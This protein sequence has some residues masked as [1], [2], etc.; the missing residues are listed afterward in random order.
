MMLGL[1]ARTFLR[2][3]V[4][5]VFAAAAQC[6]VSCLQFNF[7]CAGLP[8]LP[9]RLDASV[10]ERIRRS[11]REHRLSLAAVSGT[12]NMI[13]PD[14]GEREA[15]LRR[16]EVVSAACSALGTKLVTLCTGTRDPHDM[17]R[18]HADNATPEAWRDLVHSLTRA[19]AIAERYDL[20][21]G[22]EPEITNVISSAPRARQLLDELS[23]PRLKIILDAAN[24]FQP[25]TLERQHQ[26]LEEAFALLGG[27]LVLVHGKELGPDGH[28][29]ALPLGAG[30][31]DWT[32][33]LQLLR[34]TD[35]SGPLILHGFPEQDTAA[36]VRFV[37]ERMSILK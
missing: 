14:A 29:S 18:H 2:P 30:V 3:R 26:I 20:T 9:D 11:A 8:S 16:L 37:R 1:F 34:Q 13:H 21:L 24:L 12:F 19:L 5:E 28:A 7:A 17:W 4:E 35:F 32:H 6:G 36:S 27:D 23:A 33:Y 15:G 22:V 10:L 25:H 31:L